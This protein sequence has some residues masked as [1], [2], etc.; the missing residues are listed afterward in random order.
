MDLASAPTHMAGVDGP[1]RFRREQAN[2]RCPRWCDVG[3]GA[4]AI[5]GTVIVL[6]AVVGVA[7]VVFGALVTLKFPDRPGGDLRILGIEV[8]SPAAGL[9]LIVLGVAAIG[10]AASRAETPGG[11][12]DGGDGAP[13]RVLMVYSSL[14]QRIPDGSEHSN[15]R[16]VDM[17]NAIS[18]A[19]KQADGKAGM[20]HVRYVPLDAT[21]DGGIVTTQTIERNARR[22]ANDVDTAV[23]IGDFSSTSSIVSIPILSDAEVPQIS[24]SSTRVGLTVED[25]TGDGDEPEKYYP[26]GTRNF[27]RIIPHDNVQAA[28]LVALMLE[29]GCRRVAM[30]YDGQDYSDGLSSNMALLERPARV[31]RQPVR[32]NAVSLSRSLLQTAQRNR[33]DCFQYSGDNNPNTFGIFKAFAKALPGKLLYG[34][35]GLNESSFKDPEADGQPASFAHRV[36]LMVPPRDPDRYRSFLQDM[37]DE[38]PRTYSGGGHDPCSINVDPYAAYAYEAMKLALDATGRTERA[39]RSEILKALR[40]TRDRR[41]SVLGNYSIERQSG[42]TTLVDYN[43]SRIGRDGLTCPTRAVSRQRLETVTRVLRARGTREPVPIIP[44]AR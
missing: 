26:N 2:G 1:L 42:D 20:F 13:G 25:P 36:R 38:Y 8:R 10:M 28:A 18:L 30:I 16:S 32:P 31:L 17:E 44:N 24:P 3:R 15:K 14:P 27:V 7:L 9:P 33:A 41:D 34:T 23:Y 21:N 40:G 19:L 37:A 6:L 11:G 43:V 39:T 35:D 22:A 4:A 5:L 29:D 12:G